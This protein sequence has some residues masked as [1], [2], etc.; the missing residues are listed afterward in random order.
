MHPCVCKWTAVLLV[1]GRC[2]PITIFVRLPL[3]A[4][5]MLHRFCKA[6]SRADEDVAC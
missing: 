1:L 5:R 6:V 2:Y 4:T 3:L